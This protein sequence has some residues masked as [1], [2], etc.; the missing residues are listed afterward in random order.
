LKRRFDDAMAELASAY[1]G[2]EKFHADQKEISD[3][4]EKAWSSDV[5]S[6]GRVL[7]SHLYVEYYLNSYLETKLNINK[8]QLK[9]L[10]FHQKIQKL[11]KRKNELKTLSVSIG[12]VNQVRNKM[13]HN[14]NSMVSNEDAEYFKTVDKF[15]PYYFIL[16]ASIDESDPV[17]IYEVYCQFIAQKIMEALNPKQN[18]INNVMK[19][20]SRDAVDVYRGRLPPLSETETETC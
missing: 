6:I 9:E 7:R 15:K 20:I 13:S 17:R 16:K 2:I 4:A 8:D 12:R 10:T 19:A 18:F 3:E 14:L 5:V 11:K 1:G